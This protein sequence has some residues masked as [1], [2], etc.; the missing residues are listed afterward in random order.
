MSNEE[1]RSTPKRGPGRPRGSRT[2]RRAL[3]AKIAAERNIPPLDVMLQ[4]MTYF[5]AQA[6]VL[7]DEL[8]K[9]LASGRTDLKTVTR[10]AKL[11]AQIS[12][13]RMKSQQCA[14]D[15][16]PYVHRRMAPIKV[17]AEHHRPYVIEFANDA[18]ADGSVP[19]SGSKKRPGGV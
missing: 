11:E 9:L 14:V 8:E 10:I 6:T 1:A 7:T 17:G 3:S 13:A 15:A 12:D 4:N 19:V 16:A 2:R 5:H 18:G